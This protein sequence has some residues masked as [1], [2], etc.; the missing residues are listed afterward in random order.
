MESSFNLDEQEHKT[1]AK[2]VVALERISSAFR[3]LLWQES[4]ENG[5][6][7]IQIQILIFLLFHKASQCKVAYLAEE[8][9]VTKPTIS[10]S[11]KSLLQK[12]LIT[13][14]EDDQDAR[15]YSLAL[16]ESGKEIAMQSS[17]FAQAIEQPIAALSITQ[18]ATLL[19]SL[20]DLMVQLNQRGIITI[21]RM[22]FNCQFY[23]A[24]ADGHYCNFLQKP[25]MQTELRID[26]A[27][28]I[29]KINE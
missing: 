5:L 11:V 10:D 14:N 1:E 9:N 2:I 29:L 26:C 22:C 13:K 4:K 3:V 27:E 21:Q 8:F 23:Q 19:A 17:H 25:L 7:P 20:M 28:H 16:T 24:Q 6:S 18:K 12:N 15:S